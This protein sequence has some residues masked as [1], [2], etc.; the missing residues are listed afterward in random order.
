[1]SDAIDHPQS[2]S[3]RYWLTTADGVGIDSVLLRGAPGRTAAVVL[4]NGFTGSYRSPHTRAIAESF[5]LIADVMTFDFRGHHGSGGYSTVGDAEIHDLE[6]VVSHLRGLGYTSIA[7]VGFSMGAAVVVRHAAVYKGV[8]AAVSISAPSRWYYRGTRRMRLIH[9]G[10]G[11]TAGRF[12]LRS[13]R[14]VRVADRGWDTRP[15]EP[16]EIAGD[17]APAPLLVVHGEADTYFPTSHATAIYEA[18]ADPRELWIVPGMGH[19]EPAV[20]PELT[21]RLR[22]WL[23]EHLALE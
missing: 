1:M 10:V 3:Q 13:F 21:L 15:A 22:S 18:A 23:R 17:V 16:R 12:F 4:A 2:T 11:R 9:L 7:T 14:K 5:S 6:A 8:A 20:S 19:A